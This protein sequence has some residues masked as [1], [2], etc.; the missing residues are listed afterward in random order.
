MALTDKIDLYTQALNTS[1]IN[2]YNAVAEQADIDDAITDVTSKGR[3]ENYPWL[4]PPPWMRQWKGYRQ[5]AKLGETNYRVP[6]L[7]YTAEFEVLLEDL[8]DDQIEGFKRQAAAMAT[9]AKQWR[10]VQSLVNLAAGQTTACFDGSNFFASSHTIGSGNN[11]VTGTAAGSDGVTH[12]AVALV[13]RNNLVKPM[14]WQLREPP[15]F[16]TD[17]GDNVSHQNRMVRW[18]SDMRAAAA[19]GFWWDAILIKWSNTP[20][21]AEVQTTLGTVNARFRQFTLPKNRLDDI[22]Q[23]QHGQIKFDESTLTIVCS[24]LIE[25]I[26]RQALT[27]SLIAQTENYYKGF[28]RLACSGY[29]DAVV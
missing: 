1:F 16:R 11:I 21:V 10:V 9:M 26:V 3:V 4:Y 19:F 7:T 27:L 29:L 15:D 2:S 5:Y 18:W 20:T 8:D 24:T 6:N 13:K 22:N 17:A 14:M 28:A 12:A 25:H 23:Y